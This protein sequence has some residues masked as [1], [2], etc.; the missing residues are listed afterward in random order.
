VLNG[1][2]SKTLNPGGNYSIDLFVGVFNMLDSF[3]GDLDL[4]MDRDAGYV[5][6]P[7]KPRSFY[8]GFET[9]F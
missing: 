2:L 6:G 3:Q 4:G 1:K 9:S 7:S 5:Y 8:A